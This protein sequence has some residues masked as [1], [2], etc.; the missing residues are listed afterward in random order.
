[1]L[2]KSGGGDSEGRAT[3]FLQRGSMYRR[4]GKFALELADFTESLRYEPNS[5]DAH[6]GPANAHCA[7]RER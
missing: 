5:G 2:I 3:A 4:L 1:V 6:T 7:G